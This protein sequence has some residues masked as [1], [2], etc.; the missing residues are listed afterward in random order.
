MLVVGESRAN[1]ETLAEMLSFSG[2][3]AV[4]A[5]SGPQAMAELHNSKREEPLRAVII[6]I[7]TAGS[8]GNSAVVRNIMAWGSHLQLIIASDYSDAAVLRDFEE[9][10]FVGTITRPYQLLEVNRAMIQALDRP[11][12]KA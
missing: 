3:K 8:K 12:K 7:G 2:Y 1:F 5:H 11:V 4:Y 6:D 9:R 10:G